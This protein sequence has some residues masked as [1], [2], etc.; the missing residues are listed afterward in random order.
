MLIDA[1]LWIL[2]MF[3]FLIGALILS[4]NPLYAL[5]LWIFSLILISKALNFEIDAEILKFLIATC[6]VSFLL[7]LILPR[8]REY[9]LMISISVIIGYSAA[10]F[11]FLKEK[12]L[13]ST[14]LLYAFPFVIS[15]AL[16]LIS[17]LLATFLFILIII[18]IIFIK[19][20][21]KTKDKFYPFPDRFGK[22]ISDINPEGYV[23]VFGE[24][25]FAES[26]SWKISKGDEIYVKQLKEGKVI[27]VPVIK[28]PACGARYPITEVPQRCT[29]CGFNLTDVVF[30]YFR[31]H[32]RKK[33]V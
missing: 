24:I 28:C 2:S 33:I 29:S 1:I 13:L 20:R 12:D 19:Q 25:W 6:I 5:S 11:K 26:P 31:K 4:V 30:D 21:Q 17:A 23:R 27:V 3:I 16:I 8:M 15:I 22:A 7:G 10:S 32:A 9:S 14:A 18:V